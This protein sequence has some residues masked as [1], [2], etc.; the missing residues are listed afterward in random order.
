MEISR[1]REY[2]LAQIELLEYVDKLCDELGI[3]Y[4]MIGGTL[5]G[6][7]RHGGFIPWDADMDIAMKRPDYETFRSYFADNQVERYMY[8]HYSTDK[9]H[10][11][12]HAVLRIKG[13]H[14]NF[15]GVDYG[16]FKS[17][18]D[19][20]F[21]DVFPLDEPPVEQKARD[22][23]AKQ[24]SRLKKLIY[25]KVSPIFRNAT[26]LKRFGKR[27][28]RVAMSVV[29]MTTLLTHLDKVMQRYTGSGSGRLVSMASHYSYKKQDMPAEVYGT[30]VRINYEGRQFCAPAQTEEY[31]T[32]IYRNYMELPPENKRYSEL[33]LIGSV[34]YG[35][36][37]STL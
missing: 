37:E 36:R 22:R 4:Y 14:V 35:T 10:F 18:N 20:I 1:V 21:L 13:T 15:T 32:R 5:L 3:E 2:Q 33:N 11:S 31:L 25:Y 24:L 6:A 28:V 23:Q 17:K 27:C 34:D 19:G 29:S 16:K 26:P 12:P 30:P 7:V 8:Q 9:Q